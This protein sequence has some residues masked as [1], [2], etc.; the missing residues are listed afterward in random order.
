[1]FAALVTATQGLNQTPTHSQNLDFLDGYILNLDE[2]DI[3]VDDVNELI[4]Y[5]INAIEVDDCPHVE[6]LFGKE[7]ITFVL[8]SG[9]QA[10]IIS[11]QVNDR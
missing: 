10:S 6:V 2:Y 11:E 5:H 9:A 8:D 4:V 7:I 3:K 1:L